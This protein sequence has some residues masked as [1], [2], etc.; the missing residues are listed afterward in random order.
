M[1]RL[2]F[3]VILTACTAI[4]PV[5]FAEAKKTCLERFQKCVGHRTQLE[6]PFGTCEQRLQIAKKT[7]VWRNSTGEG[8]L[9]R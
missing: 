6:G 3:L 8:K 4:L 2:K 5:N 7:G 1:T 9:C